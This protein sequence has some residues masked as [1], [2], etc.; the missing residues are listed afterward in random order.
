MELPCEGTRADGTPTATPSQMEA[1]PREKRRIDEPTTSKRA[2][3]RTTQ[4]HSVLIHGSVDTAAAALLSEGTS[5]VLVPRLLKNGCDFSDYVAS[6]PGW[7]DDEDR[8]P[9]EASWDRIAIIDFEAASAGCSL[10]AAIGYGRGLPPRNSEVRASAS[11]ALLE[12]TRPLP[13]ALA[14]VVRH[15]AADILCALQRHTGRRQFLVRLEFVVGDTCPKWHSD[16][17]ISRS[18]V[19]Y[20][21][22]GTVCAHEFGVT[23]GDTGVVEDVSESAA[24]HAG[25]GDF[26]LMK[27]GKWPGNSGRGTAHHAPPIGAVGVCKPRQFRLLLKVDELEPG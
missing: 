8:H 14:A 23:R 4:A 10:G 9:L 3:S 6:C 15:D 25:T 24:V 5:A 7:P 2:V 21:G 18:L 13:E 20:A 19:T 16:N 11:D 17:N 27:G 22:P 1:T 26:L 12:V